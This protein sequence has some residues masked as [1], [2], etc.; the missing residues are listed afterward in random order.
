MH[1]FLLFAGA[2]QTVER[3]GAGGSGSPFL[4]EWAGGTDEIWR[5][6]SNNSWWHY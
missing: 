2:V 4:I 5:I 6:C 3:T 1:L